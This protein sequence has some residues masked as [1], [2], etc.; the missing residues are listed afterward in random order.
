MVEK[1]TRARTALLSVAAMLLAFPWP[2]AMAQS[3]VIPTQA[4]GVSADA[5]RDVR[6]EW[7]RVGAG[8]ACSAK[9]PQRLPPDQL[10]ALITRSCLHLGPLV[11]GDDADRATAALG[12]P[13]RTLKQPKGQVA[14]VYFIGER[15]HYPYFVVT[16]AAKKVVALQV[17]GETPAPGYDF[18]HV[19]L[20]ATSDELVAVFGSPSH[21]EP[22]ELKDTELWTYPSQ[23]FS[24]EIKRNR[25][26]SIRIREP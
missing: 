25:V 9:M 15:D 17:T 19:A 16:V 12:Q 4:Q 1:V 2:A 24:F 18:N 22:S 3:A 14:W 26:S 21:F 8:F 11:I 6:G 7:K 5:L 23:P 10:E 13:H 20:G